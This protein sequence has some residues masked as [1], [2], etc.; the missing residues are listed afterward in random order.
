VIAN[1][2]KQTGL[3]QRQL[4]DALDVTITTVSNWETGATRPLL[5]P[6][7]MLK[8]CQTLKCSLEQLADAVESRDRQVA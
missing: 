2:R 3:T 1:L 5:N 6:S 4:A 8:L 7:K